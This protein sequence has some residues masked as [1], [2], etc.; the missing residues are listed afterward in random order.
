MS[1]S[2][3]M[4]PLAPAPIRCDLPATLNVLRWLIWETFRQASASRMGAVFL[5]LTALASLFCA[6]VRIHG[7]RVDKTPHEILEFVPRGMEMDDDRKQR[8][9]V[10]P[11]EG[12]TTLAF[13]LVRIPHARTAADSAQFI[14]LILAVALAGTFGLLLALIWTAGFLPNFLEPHHA[15]VLLTKPVPGSLLLWGKFLGLVL[16]VGLHATVFVGATWVA[17]GWA[18]G[19]WAWNYSWAVP[20]LVLQFATFFAV[21]VFLAVL[22]RQTVVCLL[23]SL[24]F[25]FLC[26]AVNSSRIEQFVS[27]SKASERPVLGDI[28]YWLLPKPL[29]LYSM[30][31]RALHADSYLATWSAL[32]NYAHRV[33]VP[34]E[35]S[36]LTSLV[37]A[38]ALLIGSGWLLR[39]IDY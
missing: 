8:A 6:G 7:G 36:V 13:G 12:E 38:V 17:L 26:S 16:Y 25:W 11:I 19:V 5:T 1:Y 28:A 9:G 31:S 21:S 4:K 37:F 3:R 30:L 27:A 23:G 34:W 33:D 18:T 2:W 29:D 15:T 10:V 39:R 32:Q 22:T 35:A 20:L 24:G 14:Q